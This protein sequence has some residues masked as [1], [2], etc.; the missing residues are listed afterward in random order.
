M[1]APGASKRSVRA[2]EPETPT[3]TEVPSIL[4]SRSAGFSASRFVCGGVNLYS[5]FWLAGR[6]LC[7]GETAHG[8]H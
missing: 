8:S 5:N 4:R 6:P 1:R 3:K 2:V 7:V